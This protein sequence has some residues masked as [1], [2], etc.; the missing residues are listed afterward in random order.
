MGTACGNKAIVRGLEYDSEVGIGGGIVLSMD[1]RPER[2]RV[3][4]VVALGED[5]AEERGFE[6]Q[7]LP[8]PLR[9]FPKRTGER[10]DGRKMSS[11]R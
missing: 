9:Y 6:K 10:E 4:E 2:V 5:R 1:I 11:G 3:A 8:L 7:P